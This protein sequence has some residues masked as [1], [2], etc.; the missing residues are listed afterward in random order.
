MSLTHEDFNDYRM[1]IY[2]P[3]EQPVTPSAR[4]KKTTSLPTTRQPVDDFKKSI[5]RDKTHYEVLKE[6]KQWD[7][8]RR[9]TIATA[10]SHG[11]EDVFDPMYTPETTEDL[12]LFIEKQ[13][14]IYSVF[15]DCLQTDTGKSLVCLHERDY[16]A[17]AIYEKLLAHKAVWKMRT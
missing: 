1:A 17:Q 6:D 2:N 14:F 13:K 12:D 15:N 10:R 4:S 5:K 8:Q 16:N 11:Y 3:Y 9:A 7:N